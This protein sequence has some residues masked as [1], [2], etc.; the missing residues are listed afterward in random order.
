MFFTNK[1]RF[2]T[3]KDYKSLAKD[4]GRVDEQWKV[5]SNKLF[6]TA[7]PPE[8]Y[9]T[10]FQH[11]HDSGLTIPCGPDEGW[12]R[13]IVEKPFGKDAKTAERLDLEVSPT[14]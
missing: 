12:T 13:V 5:C 8:Y 11:L 9:Q 3:L 6:Y 4:L 10:I 7:V 2:E 14:I 1:G